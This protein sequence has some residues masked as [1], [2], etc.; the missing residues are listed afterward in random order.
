MQNTLL[1]VAP[2]IPGGD[3]AAMNVALTGSDITN[4]GE[5]LNYAPGQVGGNF[6]HGGKTWAVVKLDPG[7][8]AVTVGQVLFWKTRGTD[9]VVTNVV[10]NAINGGTT[11]AWRNQVAGIAQVA[12]ATPNAT[13]G[14]LLCILL[15][16]DSITVKASAG[17]VGDI[18]VADVAANV[19]QALGIGVGTAPTFYPIG[20]VRT[21][22]ASTVV[23]ADVRLPLV[24]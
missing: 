7:A 11:H 22:V 23:I 17:A 2:Y 16:G 12:I 10:A 20:T 9:Y 6:K 4:P 18:I 24:V 15:Q 14:N 21:A 5:F 3:P 19:G 13:N 1:I 8:S